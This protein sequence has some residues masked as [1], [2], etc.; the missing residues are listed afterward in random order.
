MRSVPTLLTLSLVLTACAK[1]ETAQ[2]DSAAATP[3]MTAA[4]TLTEADV[5]GTWKGTAMAEGSD[6]VMVH[7]T[8]VCAGGTCTGTTEESKDT[9]MSTYRLDADSS[10]GVSS[11]FTD[12]A[13]APVPLVDHYVVRVSGTT[14]TGTGRFVLADKPDSVVMRFRFQG[15][16]VP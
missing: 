10:I 5:A 8:Q 14:V 9:V 15:A 11:P 13:I 6:S 1:T 7:W 3:T 4:T 12:P 16:R 2:T